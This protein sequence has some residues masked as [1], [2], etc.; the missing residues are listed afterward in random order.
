MRTLAFFFFF[1]ILLL[2]FFLFSIL[3]RPLR[4]SPCGGGRVEFGG[5]HA[6]ISLYHYVDHTYT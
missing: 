5:V 4:V 2:L 3:L 1:T 6:C